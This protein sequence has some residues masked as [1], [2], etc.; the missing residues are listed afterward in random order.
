VLRSPFTGHKTGAR[1]NAA[2]AVGVQI[3]ASTLPGATLISTWISGTDGLS[4]ALLLAFGGVPERPGQTCNTPLGLLVRAGPEEFLLLP[5]S[6]ENPLQVVRKTITSDIGTV[7]DLSHA[8]CRIRIAGPQCQ[9]TLNKLF[10][11]DLRPAEFPVG[12]VRLTG[13]HHVPCMLHRQGPEIVDMLVFSTYAYDQLNT[14]VD[15]ALE[16]GV[17][18]ALANAA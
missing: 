18:V 2:G 17:D 1:P 4:A 14:V 15:A 6:A 10:A 5:D 12:E 11:L 7:T 3:A 9:A 8:R 13:T 16:Y